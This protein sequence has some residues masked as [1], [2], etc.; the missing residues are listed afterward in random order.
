MIP[1]YGR[2]IYET[3]LWL[4]GGLVIFAFFGLG[5]D[6]VAMYRSS[7]RAMGCGRFVPSFM[8]SKS[9]A[10]RGSGS[11]TDSIGSFGSKAKMFFSKRKGSVVSWQKD[12]T[13]VSGGDPVSPKSISFLEAIKEGRAGTK[14]W[15]SSTG[16]VEKVALHKPQQSIMGRLAA[17]FT[18]KKT[19]TPAEISLSSLSGRQHTVR[20]DVAAGRFPAAASMHGHG[21]GSFEVIVRK[22]VRQNSETA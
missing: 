6:A 21:D 18:S 9:G 12:S 22:E 16:D 14:P 5:K 8:K 3:Y 20:V 1:S 10:G 15:G 4:A 7:L 19:P 17:M 2:P 11:S 13:A